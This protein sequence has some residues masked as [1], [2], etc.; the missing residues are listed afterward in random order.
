MAKA[1][2]NG[3][4][5]LAEAIAILLQNQASFLARI[6]D[7]DK[8]SAERFGRIETILLEHSRILAEHSRILAEQGRVLADHSRVLADQGLILRSLPDAIRDKIGF[9]VPKPPASAD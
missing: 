8:I 1:T 3:N 9:K 4:G 2:R 5:R 6:S 7:M